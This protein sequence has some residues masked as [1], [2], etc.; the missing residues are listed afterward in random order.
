MGESGPLARAMARAYARLLA[1]KDEYEVARLLTQ[2]ALQEEMS[3]VFAPGGRVSFNL[4]PPMLAGTGLNGRPR[5]REFGPW[6][7]PLLKVLARARRLRGTPFDPFGYTAER[8]KE[9]ALIGEYEELVARV[10]GALNISNH[11]AA[12][13]LLTL[14]EEIRGF[15]LVKAK[16]MQDYRQRAKQ[17]EQDFQALKLAPG[18]P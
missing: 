4:A 11:A 17:L 6:L 9:R 18:R 14:A 1:Y 16:A 3:R 10:L 15:G 5:K 12:V 2:P 13:G 8:R 7:R